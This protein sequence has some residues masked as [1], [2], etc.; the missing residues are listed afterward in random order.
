[1]H[2]LKKLED[3]ATDIL[4]IVR[5]SPSVKSNTKSRKNFETDLIFC[6]HKMCFFICIGQGAQLD[7]TSI[8]RQI[9]FFYQINVDVTNCRTS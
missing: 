5:I 6:I 9:V 3:Q 4:T 7:G 1:M 2:I 8:L